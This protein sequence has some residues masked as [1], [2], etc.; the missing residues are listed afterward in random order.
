MLEGNEWKSTMQGLG[1][2][3]W[4]VTVYGV[5]GKDLSEKV[6]FEQESEERE[7]VSLAGERI[8]GGEGS[9]DTTAFLYL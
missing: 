8:E 7:W 6:I 9:P 2:A 5:V 4:T 1:S 3:G